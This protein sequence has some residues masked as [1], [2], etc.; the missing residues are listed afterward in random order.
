M[1]SAH[2]IRSFPHMP[3]LSYFWSSPLSPR[4]LALSL[5]ILSEQCTGIKRWQDK[6]NAFANSNAIF[7]VLWYYQVSLAFMINLPQ[8]NF[9]VYGQCKI[10]KSI[11]FPAWETHSLIYSKNSVIPVVFQRYYLKT[12]LEKVIYK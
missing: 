10:F 2:L 3:P 8:G 9:L 6:K 7:S 1:V 5:R 4:G 11:K 12:Y